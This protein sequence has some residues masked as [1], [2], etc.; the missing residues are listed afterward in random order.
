[1]AGLVPEQDLQSL[2]DGHA[3]YTDP[4]FVDALEAILSWFPYSY[5]QPIDVNY[6]QMRTDVATGDALMMLDGSWSSVP[7]SP[8]YELNPDL[9]LGFMAISGPGAKSALI[10]DGGYLVNAS[11]NKLD[12]VS[13]VLAFATTEQFGQLFVEELQ[14][15]TMVQ[16]SYLLDSAVHTRVLDELQHVARVNPYAEYNLNHGSPAY[17]RLVGEQLPLL[18][19]GMITATEMAR[20]VQA[21]LNSW[22]YIGAERCALAP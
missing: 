9:Q 3:C 7:V 6:G 4:V 16:G 2:V 20:A 10:P 1:M 15:N 18:L 13:Q 11:S 8:M 5:A 21:G 19:A 17:F 12:A 14:E 22:D